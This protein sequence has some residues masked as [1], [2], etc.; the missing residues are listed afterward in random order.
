MQL[1]GLTI[2]ADSSLSSGVITTSPQQWSYA[3]TVP[4]SPPKEAFVDAL[5]VVRAKVEAGSIGVSFI[6]VDG[7][8]V[9]PEVVANTSGIVEIVSS[10]T[11]AAIC[12]RNIGSGRSRFRV[13]GCDFY[14][15][16]EW[17][18]DLARML[19]PLLKFPGEAAKRAVAGEAWREVG[20]LVG[21]AVALDFANLWQSP[22]E[23][24]IHQATQ[25]LIGLVERYAPDALGKNLAIH[26]SRDFARKYLR[27]NTIRV[28]HLVAML[29]DMGLS[30]G[31]ILEIGGA[32]GSFAYVLQRLGY[33]VTVI[34]RYADFNGAMN[35]YISLMRDFGVE[36]IEASRENE[37]ERTAALGEYDAV[38]SMA[39]IEHIPHTPRPF[40]E[41][42]HSHV[43]PGGLLAIDTPNIARYWARKRINE[44]LSPYSNMADQFNSSIPFE[45]HHREYALE[46][47]AWMLKAIGL[48]DVR[49]DLFDYNLLQ[50][51][52]IEGDHLNA[53]LKMICDPSLADTVLGVGRKL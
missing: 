51:D 34:D 20:A 32:F 4:V 46:E 8:I 22:D 42:L 19:P 24:L 45:G 41:M 5:A 52:R 39:V 16:R 12:F 7:N 9:S 49:T 6:D 30:G 17:R 36:V 29:R 15:R 47:V 50:F 35:P 44:G 11:P 23:R 1:L 18:A 3:A 53:L 37:V 21:D 2:H 27:Q 13:E 25:E 26:I 31:R 38:I 28:V 40:L 48:V 10:A 33:Q 43:R 14:W